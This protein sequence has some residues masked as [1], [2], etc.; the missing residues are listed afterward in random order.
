MAALHGDSDRWPLWLPVA[1]GC[2]I[3]GYFA[4]AEEPAGWLGAAVLAILVAAAFVLRARP[5][6]RGVLL[7]LA[8]IAAGFAAIQVSAWTAD[9]PRIE[10]RLPATTVEAR[11][12]HAGPRE[13]GMRM[14]V[15]PLRIDGWTGPLPRRL[16]ITVPARMG[17][18]GLAPGRRVVL[19]A[20]L[21]PLPA[22]AVPDAFDFQRQAYFQGLGGL[23]YATTAP[24]LV[25]GEAA[26]A[27]DAI[28]GLRHTMTQRIQ[29]AIGGAAGAVAAALVTGERTAIPET[30]NVA[31]RDT[32]LAHLLSISGLHIS[33]VAGIV[34]LALRT[35]MAAVPGL[36]LYWPVKKWA[37]LGAIL[38][39]LFYLLLSGS[40]VPTQRS[41]LMS[42]IVFAAMLVDREA[43]SLR[44]VAWAAAAILLLVPEAMVGASFQMSFAAVLALVAA[45]EAGRPRIRALRADLGP[46]GR[47]F[48]YVGLL[49]FTTVIATAATTPFAL[50][51]FNRFAAYAM[52]ANLIAVP[53]TSFWVMPW[54]VVAVLAMPFGLEAWPLAAM[55]WGV[56]L[57]LVAAA[58]IAAWPGA[59]WT[60]PAMPVASLALCTLG[61]LWLCLWRH[62]MRLAGLVP[63]LL[64]LLGIGW[65]QPPDVL[66]DGDA[67]AVA[68]RGPGGYWIFETRAA[69]I[70]VDTWLRRA[71]G[72]RL[73]W[74]EAAGSPHLLPQCDQRLCRF[75]SQGQ[76]VVVARRRDGLTEACRSAE[77][78]IALVPM[79][80][81]CGRGVVAI[82]RR[83]LEREGA[84]AIRLGG[85]KA[86]VETVAAARGRR[87][88]TA[89]IAADEDQ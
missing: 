81:D 27:A 57:I 6:V 53:L 18:P 68:V 77:V 16:R 33:L 11:I 13:S 24:R 4:L 37:A 10:R 85:G 67:R 25:E 69:E 80:W 48:L 28:A 2:G 63:I 65:Y 58:W 30:V 22:P 21:L 43:I 20:V 8:A 50:Y 88:W 75:R 84:H 5:V 78:V 7:A 29:A 40:E 66:V 60:V 52:P 47:V 36:A 23:G 87:P 41:F 89:T 17:D 12:E 15:Q 64:G 86:Q 49:C 38:A 19:R 83:D 54:A 70:V 76:R 42:A 9:A 79:R 61:G 56:E 73:P 82:D 34:F 46:S 74:P 51:H 1:I 72:D 45:Y 71:A 3:A 31:M 39:S 26:G 32:G 59:A 62:A 55:G 35:L 14:V 44:L